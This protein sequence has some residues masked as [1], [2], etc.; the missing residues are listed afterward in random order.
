MKKI[1]FSVGI[2]LIFIFSFLAFEDASAQTCSSTCGGTCQGSTCTSLQKCCY[3]YGVGFCINKESE[4]GGC[5]RDTECGQDFYCSSGTCV[6]C[7]YGKKNC[8]PDVVGCETTIGTINNCAYCGDTCSNGTTCQGGTCRCPSGSVTCSNSYGLICCGSGK[9]CYNNA[10][11][12]PNCTGKVCGPDGCGGTC[13]TCSSSNENCVNGQCVTV[14]GCP[15]LMSNGLPGTPKVC[16][17]GDTCN[18]DACNNIVSGYCTNCPSC[19][20]CV[21]SSCDPV[22][23]VWTDFG[24][25]N[26]LG[27]QYRTCILPSCG[28]S[29]CLGKDYRSCTPPE[30]ENNDNGGDN[31]NNGGDNNGGDNNGGNNNNGTG[32]SIDISGGGIQNP[33]KFGSLGDLVGAINSFIFTVAVAVAPVL[34]VIGGFMIVTAGGN[35][36][37]VQ[38]AQ[39][40]MLYTA[41]GLAVILLAQA[42]VAV[43]KNVIGVEEDSTTML[44]FIFSGIWSIESLKFKRSK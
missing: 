24:S 41:I 39:K 16:G 21:S 31:N 34:F 23:G 43:I 36:L 11:C 15:W 29:D 35:P 2:I 44:P 26:S 3:V 5:T 20:Q 22:D 27:Y 7:A 10:C 40:L 38:K 33:L 17:E 13:G 8:S 19:I 4:C 30:G 6:Q 42:I 18:Y 14:K 1:Y 25:C 32:T 9:V 28:G 37:Q 12:T